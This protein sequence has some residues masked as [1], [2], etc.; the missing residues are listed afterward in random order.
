MVN[1][2]KFLYVGDLHQDELIPIHRMDD[3]N[4]TR[5]EKIS[6]ILKISVENVSLETTKNACSVFDLN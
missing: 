5:K 2:M 6:E 4:E 1:F 3:F